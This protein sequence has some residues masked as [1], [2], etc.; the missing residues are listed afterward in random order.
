MYIRQDGEVTVRPASDIEAG[1]DLVAA[2]R[3][4][5]TMVEPS[6]ETVRSWETFAADSTSTR[7]STRR[8]RNRTR[9]VADARGRRPRSRVDSEAGGC[10]I[11]RG[12]KDVRDW[13]Y[14]PFRI[15]TGQNSE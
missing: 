9:R 7:S 15:S 12:E 3:P 11:E 1:T 10:A 4:P 6:D 5:D 14:R 8:S 2:R 13:M